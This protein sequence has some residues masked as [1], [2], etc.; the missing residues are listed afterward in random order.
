MILL[1]ALAAALSLLALCCAFETAFFSAA[2]AKFITARKGTPEALV[3]AVLRKPDRFITTTLV[4]INAAH[5]VFAC[6]VA[7]L[8]S[9]TSHPALYATLVA[10]PITILFGELLPKSYARARRHAFLT[11]RIRLY[12]ALEKILLPVSDPFARFAHW[13][14]ER[15]FPSRT[16]LAGRREERKA[17]ESLLHAAED[18][19]DLDEVET[20]RAFALLDLR[21][22]ALKEVTIPRIEAVAFP[23]E[24]SREEILAAAART[25]VSRFPLHGGTLDEILGVVHYLDCLRSPD[26][27][28]RDLAQ[29]PFYLPELAGQ[30]AALAAMLRAGAH[31]AVVVDEWG[32]TAGIAT[33]EDLIGQVVGAI[34]DEAERDPVL[35]RSV[36]HGVHQIDG[37]AD[38][39]DLSRLAGVSLADE[40]AET[41]GGYLTHRFDGIPSPGAVLDLGD[42]RLTVLAS[43]PRRVLL[44]RL[45]SRPGYNEPR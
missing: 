20:E 1:I 37:R 28:P 15:F 34:T 22:G 27:T 25:G 11:R 3:L 45:A 42:F 8:L 44:C 23:I 29:P 30:G 18:G 16:F 39:D 35:V 10:A 24:A 2:R 33:L 43:D 12:L 32:G 31:F 38:L 40:D 7:Y 36:D 13:V 19:G 5:A 14:A 41:V 17:L 26:K 6:L 9:K 21:R 4:G